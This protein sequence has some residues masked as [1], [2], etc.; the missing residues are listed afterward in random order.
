MKTGTLSIH[1]ENIFPI[2]KKFL[3]SNQEV[4]L[5]ELVSNAVDATTK[6][7]T[8]ANIGEFQGELGDLRVTVIA[9]PEDK[10]LRII[11]NGIG[12]TA[13]EVEKYINQIAFSSA[14]E[15]LSQYKDA[16]NI[17]GHFGLGFYS[18]FMV[19]ERVELLTKSYKPG[20][21]AVKWSCSGNTTFDLEPVEKE[22]RGTEIILYLA[23]DATDFAQ[24]YRVNEVLNKYCKF[25]PVEVYH[26][27]KLINETH[28]IWKKTPTDLQEEDYKDFYRKLYPYSEA[29]LFW[30]H[31]N[32]DYPFNLTGVL[33]FP[34]LTKDLD[35]QRNKIQLYANQVFITDAVED[36]VPDYLTLLH[37]V[38]DSPDIPLNVSRSYLQTDANVRRISS[39]I[40]KK[41]ADKL[42]QLF[43]EDRASFEAKWDNLGVFVKYGMIRDNSFNEKARSFCLVQNTKDQFYTLDEYLAFIKVNQTNKEGRTVFLYTTDSVAQHSYIQAATKRGYDVIRLDGMIDMNWVQFI[44]HQLDNTTITRIDGDLIDR[45][46][47]KGI[48]AVSLLN[49]EEENTLKDIYSEAIG[50]P[51]IKVECQPNAEDDLPLVITKPEYQRRIFDMSKSGMFGASAIPD[52]FNVVVNTSH[53]LAK[54]LVLMPAGEDRTRMA[55]HTYELGLLAQNMLT[56]DALTAF[57]ERN[58]AMM[59]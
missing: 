17:I 51:V 56:G 22:T 53:P 46:I 1:S 5:R 47:D 25:L 42:S 59:R 40:S 35:F 58:V 16:A 32:V 31:L 34:K 33:Y 27:D 14:E 41:V 20:A 6:I 38:I 57:I 4:F 39:H 44:E 8:L 30:I 19:A 12:M 23:E 18:A 11:D 37:G 2:I 49:E 10:T 48:A 45:L 36:I 29:P 9:N 15:F 50:S 3:Y 24:S 43:H 28:P 55:K 54:R 26:Q 13:D 21:E 52:L 7:K